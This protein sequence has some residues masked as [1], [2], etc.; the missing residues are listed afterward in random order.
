MY[1]AKYLRIKKN[2][3]LAN[4]GPRTKLAYDSPHPTPSSTTKVNR[5]KYEVTWKIRL[6]KKPNKELMQRL[7][8]AAVKRKTK[9]EAK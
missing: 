1:L 5:A 6:E 4:E 7:D 8:I 9:A 2:K 3:T